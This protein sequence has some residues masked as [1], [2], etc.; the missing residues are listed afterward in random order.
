MAELRS[1]WVGK[2]LGVKI[3]GGNWHRLNGA[4][5][6]SDT[7]SWGRA[8]ET[9]DHSLLLF[10]TVHPLRAGTAF[11]IYH[12]AATFEVAAHALNVHSEGKLRSTADKSY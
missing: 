7:S 6:K 1:L 3:T 12:A 2:K 5:L 4:A 8:W 10:A 9:E 11:H